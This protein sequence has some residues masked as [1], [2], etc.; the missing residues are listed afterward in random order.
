MKLITEQNK[1]FRRY[2][3]QTLLGFSIMYA[4]L[5]TGRLN[6]GLAIPIITKELGWSTSMTGLINSVL[7]WTYGLGHLINGRLSEVIGVKRFIMAGILLSVFT[8]WTLSFF[9][10]PIAIAVLWG[11]NGYFQ[12]MVW[13]PGMSLLSKWWPKKERGFAAGFAT[14]FSGVG[15]IIAWFAVIAA[16]SMM[17][18]WGWRATFRLPVTSL[19]IISFFYWYFVKEKP[20]DVGLQDYNM[21]DPEEKRVEEKY[22][23]LIKEKGVLYPY[24]LLFGQ[25]IFDVWCFIIAFANLCSYGL[26]TWIPLYYVNVMNIPVKNGIVDS[27]VLPAGM[28][29]GSFLAPWATDKIFKANRTPVVIIC[30]LATAM[31]VFIFPYMKNKISATFILFLAGLFVY[32]INGVVWAFAVDVGSRVLAGTAAG[33]LEWAAYM[34]A[35]LQNM[36]FG[37]VLDKTGEWKILFTTVMVLCIIVTILAIITKRYACH[38][39]P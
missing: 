25:L 24:R 15:K 14:G 20:S 33:I 39:L 19:L 1:T 13:S 9:N 2:A 28:A 3:W 35:A 37:Y 23:F 32:G 29:I 26:L 34:G 38:K 6:F 7:F 36:I 16:V 12:S 4:F 31:T 27:V 30:G 8:N 5:Y 21:E 22:F 18:S 17:P 10:N 11:F